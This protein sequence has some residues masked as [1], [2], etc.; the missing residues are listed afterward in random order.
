MVTYH[1]KG[2]IADMLKADEYTEHCQ[3][4]K[5]GIMD[6][7]IILNGETIDIHDENNDNFMSSDP[8]D[9]PKP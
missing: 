3:K 5:R 8:N 2:E 7:K 9:F 1:L 4:V 6:Q